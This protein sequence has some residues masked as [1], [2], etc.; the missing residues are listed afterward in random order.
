[1]FKNIS[2]LLEGIKVKIRGEDSNTS[3]TVKVQVIPGGILTDMVKE[4]LNPRVYKECT[5][6]MDEEG[7]PMTVDPRKN[8]PFFQ[9]SGRSGD[10]HCITEDGKDCTAMYVMYEITCNL[11]QQSVNNDSKRSREQGKHKSEN[12]IGMTMTSLHCR[13]VYHLSG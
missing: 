1:M 4:S 9:E 7:I 10:P 2:H 13:M 3:R 12:Y 6:V 5:K 11:C 8:D